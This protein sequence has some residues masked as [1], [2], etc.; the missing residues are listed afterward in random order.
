MAK[1]NT[2]AESESSNGDQLGQTTGSRAR[3]GVKSLSA[4]FEIP[5]KGAACVSLMFT[6]HDVARLLAC[7]PR[8]VYRLA[9]AGRMPA[10]IRLGSLIRWPRAAIEA[11]IAEGCPA[12]RAPR[13]RRR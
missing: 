12:G 7:S 2:T 6:A 9:D 8:T 1:T 13:P 4:G 11:W 3:L 5:A 10:A